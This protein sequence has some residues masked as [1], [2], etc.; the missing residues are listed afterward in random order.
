VDP[1]PQITLLL[2]TIDQGYD[3]KSWHGTTLRAG[4]KRADGGD[5]H[6]RLD[7]I[8]VKSLDSE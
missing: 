3:R 2:K 8:E 7:P 4:W 6:R 1:D 5:R